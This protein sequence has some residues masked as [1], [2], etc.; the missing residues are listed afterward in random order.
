MCALFAAWWLLY[1]ASYVSYEN[2]AHHYDGYEKSAIFLISFAWAPFGEIGF[3]ISNYSEGISAGITA[4]AT[5]AVA[6]FTFTI[7]KTNQ[8]QLTYSQQVER[9]YISG[10]GAPILEEVNTLTMGGVTYY[11]RSGQRP[12]KHF[13]ETG[14]FRLDINN[15]GKTKG[16]IVEYGY[17]WCEVNKVADLPERPVYKWVYYRDQIGPGTQSRPIKRVKIPADK[18]II[19]GRYGYVDIFGKCHSDGFIQQA[20][21]PIAP[22]HASYTEA[23]PEWDLPN[24]GKRDY[25]KEEPQ[26]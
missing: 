24:V 16:Q 2:Q 14:W 12:V 1:A 20:G 22:P 3:F 5:V 9:A 13:R 18:R 15:H 11:P 17:G 6:W 26:S 7:W 4:A 8:N 23:D 10:G 25:K 21:I 19:F